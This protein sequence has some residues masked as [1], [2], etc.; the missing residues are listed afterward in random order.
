MKRVKGDAMR[1]GRT[2]AALLLLG[3]GVAYRKVVRPWHERWGA[4][5]EEVLEALP[6]DRHVAEPATQ[7]TRAITVDAPPEQVWPWVVQLGADRAG[8]YSYD[9]LENLFG[10]GIHSARHVVPGWQHRAVGDLVHANAAG[11]GGW[12]V[13][14][15]VPG[16]ALALELADVKAGRPV[17]RDEQLRWEFLWTFVVKDLGNGTTRLLVRERTGFGSEAT[18]LLLAPAGLVSF[19][20]TR[21]MMRGI[22]AR[23]EGAARAGTPAPASPGSRPPPGCAPPRPTSS[24]RSPGARD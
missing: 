23:A 1:R 9:W 11:T 6:G 14:E 3:T 20:M 2:A 17:R 5:D 7:H 12:Y 18:R 16:R 22:K 19:V 10:L 4:T 8:F 24:P 15:L 13:V 21:K